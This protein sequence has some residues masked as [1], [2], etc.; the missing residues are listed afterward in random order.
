MLQIQNQAYYDEVVAFAK[1]AGLYEP[2]QGE[3][4]TKGYLLPKLEYLRTYGGDPMKVRTTLYKDFAPHSF[5]F[6]IEKL[7]TVNEP[8][9]PREE[10]FRM[11]N[12]G[13]IFHGAHDNGGD[14]GAPTF[15]VSINP[16]TGW[17]IHT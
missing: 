5:E 9:G 14:G 1:K 15:S 16:S 6:V 3:D 10:W 4:E 11:F 13:L 2:P 8:G 7:R 17:Q 12:G